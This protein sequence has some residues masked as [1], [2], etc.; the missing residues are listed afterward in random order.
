VVPAGWQAA[1]PTLEEQTSK[2]EAK[3]GQPRLSGPGKD[4]DPLPDSRR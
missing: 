1:S 4:A 3:L 2:D